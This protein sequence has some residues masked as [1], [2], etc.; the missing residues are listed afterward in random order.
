MFYAA[1][2]SKGAC[3]T[4][5]ST[6]P[7]CTG[8]VFYQGY[9]YLKDSAAVPKSAV[10]GR[11][12]C[13]PGSGPAPTPSAG[14]TSA[15]STQGRKIM[16]Q[17]PRGQE[18]F[19][20]RGF[21]YSNARIGEGQPLDG[22]ASQYD[23]LMRPELCQRDFEKMRAANVNTIKV[24]VYNNN[25]A[26]SASLHKGCLDLAWNGGVKPIFISLSIWINALPMSDATYRAQILLRYAKMVEETS[27]HPAVFAYSVG[28]EFSGDPN[29][30][31][32][33]AYWTDFK[34]V[35]SSIRGAMG[36]AKKLVT[37][38]TYQTTCSNPLC[39]KKDS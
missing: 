28:S 21:A 29:V 22:Y 18:V 5:C 37:T 16:I 1:S 12:M 15:F 10:A 32:N 14:G 39:P 30:G 4:L 34:A 20:I 38:G 26:D 11:V 3:C 13:T 19:K 31:A 35:V 6:E 8:S 9:C 23:P 7:L 27:K 17:T 33:S 25:M 24:Y 36:T 2:S